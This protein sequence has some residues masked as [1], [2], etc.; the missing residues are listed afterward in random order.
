MGGYHVQRRVFLHQLR[1]KLDLAE[2]GGFAHDRRSVAPTSRT[3]QRKAKGKR[4][5]SHEAKLAKMQHS[6][7]RNSSVSRG[8][9]PM[10]ST[11]WLM[12][13][14]SRISTS[15]LSLGRLKKHIP[16]GDYSVSQTSSKG[17]TYLD[18][19]IG[20]KDGNLGRAFWFMSVGPNVFQ[21]LKLFI[22]EKKPSP[23]WA[24]NI[25]AA[26]LIHFLR[27]GQR[28]TKIC[29]L[30]VTWMVTL[31]GSR[32]TLDTPVSPNAFHVGLAATW[33]LENPSVQT[34]MGE[35]LRMCIMR[36]GSDL[37]NSTCKLISRNGARTTWKKSL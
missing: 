27:S 20:R 18:D 37:C 1:V 3:N 13:E 15:C 9:S 14:I 22:L 25:T 26:V 2:V 8:S 17:L 24:S 28:P 11:S 7:R 23:Y 4:K 33:V 16:T 10:T 31:V 21:N 6:T 5:I 29:I 35:G 30:A 32:L 34:F 19:F 36:V 12:T